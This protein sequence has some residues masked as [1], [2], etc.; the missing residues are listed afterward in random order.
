MAE[1][2]LESSYHL[3]TPVGVIGTPSLGPVLQDHP[4]GAHGSG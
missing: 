2:F 1:M 3:W 4:L